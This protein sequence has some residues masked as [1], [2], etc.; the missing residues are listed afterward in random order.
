M[1]N[2]LQIGTDSKRAAPAMS[3]TGK[4]AACL[5]YASDIGLVA[6]RTL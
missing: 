3:S 5:S 2:D 1:N 6:E 4:P